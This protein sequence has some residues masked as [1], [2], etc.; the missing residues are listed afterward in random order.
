[1]LPHAKAVRGFR[2]LSRFPAVEQD[3]ALVVDR[4]TSAADILAAIRATKLVASAEIFDEYT[5]EQLPPG[6]KSLAISVSYQAPDR[7][8]TDEDASR[9]QAR[10]L[11]SLKARF[12]ADLR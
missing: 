12:G 10:L 9:E 11:R 7:T 6:K 4:D 1:L 8:L 3:L 5:G 2:P